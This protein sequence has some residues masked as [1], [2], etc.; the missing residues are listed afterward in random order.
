MNNN[1]RTPYAKVIKLQKEL[2]KKVITRDDFDSNVEFICGVDV[3][4][5]KKIAYCSAVI[6][7]KENFDIIE[8]VSS[9]TG[10]KN[11]YIPGLFI[12]RESAPILQT[13]RLITRPFQ[14]LLVDGHGVLHPRRCGLACYVGIDTNIPTIGV[15]KSLL[16]GG[17]QSDN[18]VTHK[19]EILGYALKSNENSKKVAYVS[20]GHKIG[21]LT[22]IELVKSITKINQY[23]PEP[24]RVADKLSKEL[25]DK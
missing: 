15:A 21:L 22:S 23:I 6:I 8:T 20:V 10:I 5:R 3:S 17:V 24:L 14:L 13:L 2:A 1:N 4:Y 18:F 25:D 19:G 12:L 11:P 9:K 16:C 7:N